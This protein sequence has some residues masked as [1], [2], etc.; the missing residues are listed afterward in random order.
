MANYTSSHTGAV[1]DAAVTK[2]AA[3]TSSATELNILDGVTAT[4]AEINI[5]DGVTSTAA[6]LNIL[7][8]VTSTTAELNILDGVTATASEINILDGVTSTTAELNILD[9]VTSTA[10][11]LNIVDGGT[12]ATSTTLADADRVVVNDNGTMVQVALTDFETYFESA[13]DTLS[14]VTTVGALNS[15]SITSGFGSID[16]GSSAITTTGTITYG[17]LSDGSITITAFVDE[18]N[19]SS[20]SATLVPT[21]QSVKAY[22]DSQVTA[23]D[24]DATTDSGTIAIDLDSETL[25]IAGGEGI[26]TSGSSNTI[27]IAAEDA[28]SSNK[29]VASF[30]SDNF[31]VSSG[32]VTIKD[33]GV[34]NAEL[35]NSS[36]TF[37]QGAGMGTLGEISLGGSVTVAVD[38]VLEDLDTLGAAGSDGQVIVATGAGAFQYESG[39]TLRTSIGVDA[40]GTDNSTNVTLVTS[41]HDYLSLSGQAITLGQIDISDDTNLSAGTN[42]SLSGDTLNVDDAFLINSGND[43]TSGTITAAGFTTTGTL[44]AGL[45]DIDD[46]VINGTTIGHTDD[47]DLITLADGNVTIAGEL[48]LTTLDVSGDADIDGTLEADAITV[49]GTA[50]NTVIAGVTV[51][52]ATLAST[53]TITD[54]SDNVNYD[55]VF[56]NSTSALYDDTGALYYNPSTGTLRV[57]NLN[58]AGTTTQVDTV[59]MEAQNAVVFEG[60]TADNYETTLSIVD[61]TA[62]HTQYLI[63]QGGY[64][65]VLAAATTTA[66]SSTPAELN[67]LD[68]ATVVV[69]EINYLDLGSTAIG[70][71]IASKAVVLDANKDYTGVRNLTITGEL[72]GGSLDISG[73]ADID[74]TLETDALSI[75]GTAVSSTAAELN[76]LDGI[77]STTAE[78]NIL[79]GVTATAAELNIMDGVT[80]TTA[81]LNYTDGVTSNIQTQ[82]DSKI[83]ATLTTEQVQDIVGGMFSS[84]TETRISAT[85]EDGDGT[86]DLVVD[87]MTANDNTTYTGGTNLTLSGTTFNVDDAFLINSGNDTTS[88]TIT[89]GGFTTT[90]NLSLAGHAVN[91]IDIGSEFVDADDHLMTSGAIKEKIESYGYTTDANVTHRTI[92]AGGN[93]LAGSETLAFTAGSNVAI[94]ESGGAVTI[95]STDTNTTYTAGTGLDLSSTEFSVD[96]SD[97]MTNGSDNRIVTA[98]GTDAMNA[99]AN[100]T[101]DGNKLN[102]ESSENVVLAMDSTST[103]TFLD[104]YNDNDNRV[105]VGNANDGDFIVR[106]ADAIRLIV[107][108]SGNTGIINEL[109]HYGD[110]DTK[111]AFTADAITFTSGGQNMLVL[112][113]DST[114]Y[115]RIPD[116]VRLSVGTGNDLQLSH[117]ATNSYI[118]NYTGDLYFQNHTTDGDIHFLVD[119]GGGN[120]ITALQIDASE[121]GKAIFSGAVTTGGQLNI[122][123]TNAIIYRNSGQM[124]LITYGGY[125]IDLNPAG[126]VRIDGAS[127]MI[128][129]T[130][131][132][133][134]DGGG[135]TYILESA[136]DIMDFYAGNQLF[137]RLDETNNVVHIP[138][139]ADTAVFKMG[140]G[141]D[142][143]IYVETDDDAVIR[144]ITSDKDMIFSVNDGGSQITALQIDA[145]EVG[146][147]K[148][149]NDSQKLSIGA[150]ADLQLWHDGSHTYSKNYTGDW[151]FQNT[152]NDK[153]IVFQCDDGSGGLTAY[154]TLDGSITKTTFN[155][156]VRIVDSKKIGFGNADDLEIYHDGTD[157]IINTKGTAFKLL[158][159]GTER[160]RINSSGNIVI[161]ENGNSMDFRVEGDTDANLLFVDGSADRV[162]IGTGSPSKKLEVAGD[163]RIASGGDL[164][165]SDSAGGNDTFLYNDS[166]SLIGYI[167]GAERFRVNSSGN[168]GIAEDNIDA[169][170]HITGSPCVIKQERAGVYA[171]R[172]GIPSNSANWVLAHTDNLQSS[173]AMSINGSRDIYIPESVGIGVAAN[174]TAGRLDCSN[175]VVAYSTSD[176]RLKENIKPLDNA[177]DKVMQI[178]GVEFDWKKL[179]EKEKETIHGNKGHDVGVIAQE[180]EEVLPEVVT[181]RDNGYKAVKYEKIVPL[182]IEAIKEQ[183]EEID[184]LKANYDQL[185]YNR[186]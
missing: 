27:T 1:I 32:A 94:T 11:E 143:Q 35:V 149:P 55:V 186:R 178:S 111:M 81:E 135:D 98:T 100:L 168:V 139:D 43:T 25:T 22:V 9:G 165:L 67:I 12:S 129:A 136:T 126:D 112:E 92:T 183:Q 91:D 110:T 177:L 141:G 88:G 148:L 145:S 39:S 132:L 60:A 75:N 73:D 14:N 38:G 175:D 47:T 140:V 10:A 80:A 166:Q 181:Q 150:G 28:T 21:Q 13:L 162:G 119:D 29:G 167:N 115:V 52:N 87:D 82:L 99:E 69:G 58:V 50:L 134:L 101:F 144:N 176:K 113:E 62:D 120:D 114:D 65:P 93:T 51:S 185:K 76:V 133:Y 164:I 20:D 157:D 64:I 84:N 54:K 97:F 161:N 106:T 154:L 116:N 34:A 36:I 159:N 128:P 151:Y 153:D 16:N 83:E 26:D 18:D 142:L 146:Q 137:L 19:M 108:S 102:I 85:Y 104:L 70:T 109:Y 127:L 125:N 152:A 59:T 171:M 3:T 160:L 61:P 122:E 121:V 117:N 96:V 155:Q 77:T 156:D 174:G 68:G 4:T 124:E 33:G 24:L 103:Y 66:I 44:A 57:P 184:L 107:D 105:Q 46:V 158:D 49:N 45:A 71:A 17:S 56:G 90:G 7:D 53:V 5:L 163:V 23:Q 42:I 63:N 118:Q 6:E 131:K 78:L 169:N 40:A 2:I 182:L 86:I 172:M 79:D 173:V 123:D 138:R 170:L 130:E 74:G 31:S 89:A 48:D 95:A 30:S 15:G 180:I 41:S 37:T 72:D 8:G 147:V 179:T